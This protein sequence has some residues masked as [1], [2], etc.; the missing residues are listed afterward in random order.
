[1]P[2]TS[3]MN[4]KK[5]ETEPPQPCGLGRRILIMAYD[6]IALVAL[7]MAVTALLL[8]TPIGDQTAFVD[9]LPT[10]IMFV[11]WFLYLAWCW[12][13]GLTLGMRAWRVKLVFHGE[14]K[15]G[16]GKY[17]I[18]FI[19]SLASAACLGL[20]FLSSLFDSEHRTWHDRASDSRLVRTPKQLNSSS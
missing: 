10:V 12:R 1:M 19:V 3:G 15:P 17:A 4:S 8:M 11:T 2:E 5:T 7:M 6:A 20:G 18:R 16:W 14:E 9:P 13:R